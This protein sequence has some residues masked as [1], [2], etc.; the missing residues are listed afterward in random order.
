MFDEILTTPHNYKGGNSCNSSLVLDWVQINAK[1]PL[2]TSVG[3][4]GNIVYDIETYIN[5][6]PTTFS[7]GYLLIDTGNRTL[8]YKKL[9]NLVYND[10]TGEPIILA[11]LQM[12]PHVSFI[13]NNSCNLKISNRI[14]YASNYLQHIKTILD[15]LN[16]DFINY[17][18][19][20]IANDFNNVN[21]F[22]SPMSFIGSIASS[23]NVIAGSKNNKLFKNTEAGIQT[24][25]NNN[26]PQYDFEQYDKETYF[27][28][29]E[30]N[31]FK[32]GSRQSSVTVSMYNKT[33]ELKQKKDKPW[34]R[35]FWHI[36]NLSSDL[37][38]WR[39]EF[40]LKKDK[41]NV[42]DVLT[43]ETIDYYNIDFIEYSNIL[44][45]YNLC[46]DKHFRVACF[47]ENKQFCRMKQIIPFM[48]YIVEKKFISIRLSLKQQ[49]TNLVKHRVKKLYEAIQRYKQNDYFIFKS[50]AIASYLID[51]LYKYSLSTWFIEKISTLDSLYTPEAELFEC[52]N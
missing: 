46:L 13:Q 21:G 17:T 1:I 30:Y 11:E 8:H 28:R 9:Y 10:L 7:N 33:L 26:I 32:L 20:D 25:N 23:L 15:T 31:A 19:I 50:N 22:N 49:S 24:E 14:L 35:E 36:N 51:I 2:T 16:L 42:I 39:L 38:T 6:I 43:G 52:I 45:M 4:D 3:P 41:K 29:K 12:Y 37:D 18:R 5:N 48:K 27:K 40:S 34:I 47:E 44:S